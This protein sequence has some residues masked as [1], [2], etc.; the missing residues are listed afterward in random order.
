MTS[1]TRRHQRPRQPP[2]LARLP[3]VDRPQQPDR[4][5]LVGHLAVT[6]L[7]HPTKH[8]TT[9]KLATPKETAPNNRARAR[10]TAAQAEGRRGGRPARRRSPRATARRLEPRP[11]VERGT[12]PFSSSTP[13]NA[14]RGV[15][16]QTSTCRDLRRS[17]CKR[18]DAGRR[19]GVAAS[20]WAAAAGG[21]L[22]FGAIPR[23]SSFFAASN[24]RLLRASSCNC[25]TSPSLRANGSPDGDACVFDNHT[26][27]RAGRL[28]LL[29]RCV[30]GESLVVR[31]VSLDLFSFLVLLKFVTELLMERLPRRD[32]LGCCTCNARTLLKD[33]GYKP[34]LS[35]LSHSYPIDLYLERPV[36]PR[37]VQQPLMRIS[38]S[39]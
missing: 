26:L 32:R 15:A 12:P 11:G 39:F 5:P 33:A 19:V 21:G 7:R 34:S 16:V 18:T 3:K 27:R 31:N 13:P 2:K 29:S 24:A 22:G 8:A 36:A 17:R 14:S 10:R 4:D 25:L 30:L 35:G 6:G 9:P 1:R 20:S 37:L 23:D 28:K 38:P